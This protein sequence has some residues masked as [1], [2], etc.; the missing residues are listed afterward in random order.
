MDL[1]HIGIVV[2]SIERHGERY[3]ECLG[4]MALGPAVVDPIQD[5]RIQFWGDGK[6]TPVELIEPASENSKVSRFLAKG[7][8]LHHLCYEVDDVDSALAEAERK[9]AICVC[10]PVPAVALQQRRVCFVVYRDLGLVEFLER[11]GK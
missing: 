4:L 10:R 7:G 5:V 6:R 2:G 9:G 3:A 11:N 1:H 8:G